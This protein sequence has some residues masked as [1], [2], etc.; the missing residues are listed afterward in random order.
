MDAFYASIEQRD[1]PEWRGRPVIVGGTG[2]RGVV[3][4][5]S[6]EA[7]VFGVHSAMPMAEAR[8]RAPEAIVVTPRMDV[9]SS[10]SDVILGVFHSITPLVEPLSLDEAF[11]DVTASRALFGDSLQIAR[12]IQNDVYARTRLTISIGCASTKFVAKVAS[13]LHKPN[14]ITVVEPGTEK[15]FLAVL[16]VSRL[17][18]AGR[19]TQQHLQS[20]G[21]LTI[22]D[23]QRWTPEDLVT[24]LGEAA[25]LHF[26]ELAH[27]RDPRE[28]EPDRDAKSIGR[29]VTF[30]EDLAGD[31]ACEGVLLELC[32]SVGRR[33]RRA[34]VRGTVVKLKLRFPPFVTISRQQMLPR[35][36]H[37]DLDIYYR[38]L[39]M[40]RAARSSGTPVRLL[41]VSVGG[42]STGEVPRQRSMFDTPE[43]DQKKDRLRRAMDQIKNRF[44]EDSIR[45]AGGGPARESS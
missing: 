17:W 29:E 10:V 6:Y 40:F 9:Y 1:H 41:G 32:E 27:G 45:R 13:D 37:D 5:A 33:M 12:R 34:D 3:S 28:I 7:R 15:Q 21:L 44:G 4:T 20:L 14:G 19:V 22:G 24:T 30:S 23:V 39:E 25:G 36:S 35:P 2:R 11:L 26:H 8:L 38:V 42:L 31:D 43:E 18:G 16:P